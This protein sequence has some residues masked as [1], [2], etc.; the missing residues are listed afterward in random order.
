MKYYEWIPLEGGGKKV[1]NIEVWPYEKKY[2]LDDGKDQWLVDRVRL[3]R[4]GR[5]IAKFGDETLEYLI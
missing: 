4:D 5:L 3:Y 2:V 1:G